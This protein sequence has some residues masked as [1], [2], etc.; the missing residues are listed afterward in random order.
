VRNVRIPN[1]SPV[2]A[3]AAE[4]AKTDAAQRQ[5]QARGE[6]DSQG[7]LRA[8][9]E[10]TAGQIDLIRAQAELECARRPECVLVV[11]DSTSS[12]QVTR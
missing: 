2:S 7:I 4:K 10:L 1:S 8:A 6:A 5:E 12:V 11:G 9:A 3:P